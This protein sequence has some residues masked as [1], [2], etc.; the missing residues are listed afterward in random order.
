MNQKRDKTKTHLMTQN[1]Y[2]SKYG[3]YKA[4]PIF[5]PVKMLPS[6]N[7]NNGPIDNVCNVFVINQHPLDIIEPFIVKGTNPMLHKGFSPVLVNTVGQEFYGT[8]FETSEGIRDDIFNLRTNFNHTVHLHNPYPIK[9]NECV[10]SKCLT[11]IRG[12]NLIGLPLN[13]IYRTA[14]ITAI[15]IS[16]PKLIDEKRMRSADYIKT[17]S[18]IDC[19]FQTA[20]SGCHNMIVLPPF[21][22]YED[23]IPQED[24]VK[25][26]NSAIFKYGH[27]FKYIIIGISAQ[28]GAKVF[29]LY[30]KNIVRPQELVQEIDSKYNQIE[31][32]DIIDEG[33]SIKDKTIKSK[34]NMNDTQQSNNMMNMNNMNPMLMQMM[35]QKFMANQNN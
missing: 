29:E 14:L 24:I 30:N 1:I 27:R 35:Y 2:H 15:P 20:I 6:N 8:N 17:Y 9:D 7:W 10:Y 12:K 18:T 4:S 32:E 23:E 11:V 26:Y 25:L 19:I 22:L 31:L 3:E 5:K 21:G 34:N 13:E 16:K 28:D 33:D